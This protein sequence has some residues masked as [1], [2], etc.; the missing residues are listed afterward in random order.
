[1]EMIRGFQP[2]RVLVAHNAIRHGW[3][4]MARMME[5]LHTA[6]ESFGWETEYF[7]ADDMPAAGSN[8]FRRYAF[9]WYARR[10]ARKAFLAGRPYDVINIHEPSGAAVVLGRSRIGGAAVVVMSHGVEQRYWELRLRKDPPGPEPPGWKTRVLFPVT[11]LW[12]SRLTLCR[13]DH[14]L[15]LNEED[16][17]FL[18][19][20]FQLDPEKIT[21]VFPGTGPEFSG[22]ASRRSYERACTRLLFS[23]T[24]IERKGIRQVIEAFTVLAARHPSMRLGILGPGVPESRVLADFPESLH[25][26]ITVFP[27]LS[28]AECAEVL[29]DHDVFILPS[30]FE[31]TP[32]AL[33]EA[34]CT[35]IPVITTATC[36]MKDVV[37][38]GQNGL[39]IAPGDHEQII[40]SVELLLSDPVLRRRL[41]RQASLDVSH[42]YTWQAAA[43]LVNA[44]YCG[45]P[46]GSV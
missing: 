12:Q 37:E 9:P 21:R 39:L 17:N 45:L 42:K 31:G 24:W 23:G 26:K 46:G 36:G 6:L 19:T 10:H 11:S 14:V 1:M 41:G 13:A 29:L 38:D 40:R 5:S 18:A 28:H 30:F 27:P 3:G 4:G 44:A 16:K 33:I 8:R 2:R 22:V 43:E 15:C 35:G 34:M 25:S 20:R 32:L 7:T